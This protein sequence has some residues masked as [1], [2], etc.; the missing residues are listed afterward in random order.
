[1]LRAKH[2]TS[3]SWSYAS[4]CD[5]NS[6]TI[7]S[8]IVSWLF[9]ILDAAFGWVDHSWRRTFKICFRGNKG[10]SRCF[11][12]TSSHWE[13]EGTTPFGLITPRNVI[14]F[15]LPFWLIVTY[16]LILFAGRYERT[17]GSSGLCITYG[18]LIDSMCC[19]I[20]TKGEVFL[21]TK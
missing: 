17:Q 5:K 16:Y 11:T 18:G 2:A 8:V 12:S 4:T 20:S 13:C 1:M 14:Y 6:Y 9:F 10:S 3:C 21:H 15:S 7:K 19:E